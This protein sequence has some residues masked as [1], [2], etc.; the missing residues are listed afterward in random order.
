MR[1]KY[2]NSQVKKTL[3]EVTGGHL[4]SKG[5][6]V[7]RWPEAMAACKVLYHLVV[8]VIL[9]SISGRAPGCHT[10]AE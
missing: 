6:E 2:T 5:C 8:D 7:G 1:G 4:S 3:S 10:R 9:L